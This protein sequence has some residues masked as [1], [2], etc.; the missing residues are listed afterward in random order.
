[1]H[2]Y[3]LNCDWASHGIA[4]FKIT[5]QEQIQEI[6]EA[7]IEDLFI[8]TSKGVDVEEPSVDA[9][10]V[11]KG[12][13]VEDGATKQYQTKPL[14][15]ER[16]NAVNVRNEA[17]KLMTG[18]M[19][20]IRMGKSLQMDRVHAVV[21]DMADSIMS[22]GDLSVGLTSIKEPSQ[23]TVE[24]AVNVS[25]LLMAFER[26][27]TLDRE[28]LRQLGIGGLL[29][30]IGKARVPMHILNK[31]AALTVDERAIMQKHVSYG[32]DILRK[33]PGISTVVFQVVTE[34]HER[35]D[36]SGYPGN[37]KEGGISIYGQ[38]AAIADVYDALTADRVY[39]TS[40]TPHVALNELM[41]ARD[42]HS[43]ALV[44]QFIHGI[45]I[46]PIGS[47]VALSNG[48]FAVVIALNKDELLFPVIRVI[49]DS[50]NNQYLQSKDLDLSNQDIEGRVKIVSAV[51]PVKWK[52]KP[53][54]Y[55][56][57]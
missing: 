56:Y 10:G 35:I 50:I 44:Q 29:L 46:Y 13:S 48:C 4:E 1:M 15:E 51:D 34:H 45:G 26:S 14:L 53:E 37:I 3:N 55:L 18:I 36:G 42:L 11:A 49:Y 33:T 41:Q 38:M 5:T 27:L 19:N 31:P 7:G 57:Q 6:I 20:D 16:A 9:T 2:V 39:E 12:I 8:D 40:V 25:I 47:L 43:Q 23:Y 17:V 21:D 28:E 52:I 54:S 22:N 32:H 30:D 24:H